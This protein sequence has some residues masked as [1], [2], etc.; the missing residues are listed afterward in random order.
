MKLDTDHLAFPTKNIF[1]KAACHIARGGTVEVLGRKVN[2][3]R[4]QLRA[5]GGNG[6]HHQ[7]RS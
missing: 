6:R 5:P 2:A 1:V 7:G 4:E 3:V